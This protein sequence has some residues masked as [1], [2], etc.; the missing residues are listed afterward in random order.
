MRGVLTSAG[1]NHLPLPQRLAARSDVGPIELHVLA[2][3][4]LRVQLAST[5]GDEAEVA[6]FGG[7]ARFRR[8]Y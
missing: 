1:S 7:M 5:N 6:I 3:D 2:F 8:I 4:V